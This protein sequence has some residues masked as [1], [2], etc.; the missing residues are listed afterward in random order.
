M[1]RVYMARLAE[2]G[3]LGGASANVAPLITEP[4]LTTVQARASRKSKSVA[5][6]RATKTAAPKTPD[7]AQPKPN[8]ASKTEGSTKVVRVTKIERI[9]AL[10]SKP[11]GTTIQDIMDLTEWQ[12]HSVRG[13][14]AGT[15]K[16]KMGLSLT[17]SKPEGDIRRYRIAARR[18]R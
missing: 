14:L 2:C 8:T 15:V 17:S 7:K 16:K 4:K 18:G 3:A 10:L 12:Q 5:T 1:C 9:L 6:T 13:F 11:E